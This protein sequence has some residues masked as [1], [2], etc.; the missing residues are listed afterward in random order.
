MD[1]ILYVPW[2]IDRT[3]LSIELVGS[4]LCQ[5]QEND[6]EKVLK[7]NDIHLKEIKFNNN[8]IG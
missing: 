3:D 8:V 2:N 5:M 1:P 7:Y 6:I 4:I